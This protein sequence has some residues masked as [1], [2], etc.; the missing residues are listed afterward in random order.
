M[1][2][3]VLGTGLLGREIAIR[4]A[5]QGLRV[6]VW[7]RSADKAAPL[8][9]V[10]IGLADSAAAAIA[11]ADFTL[12]LLSDAAAIRETLFSAA[13]ESALA[14][15]IIV[16][17]GTI[18]PEESRAIA[19]TVARAGGDYLEAP[20]LGSLP[21]AR[22][23]RLIIMAGGDESLYQRC[24]P[25]FEALSQSPQRVGEIG[26]GAALKLAMNQLIAGLTASF[27]YSLG[28]VRSE[29]LDVEQFMALLRQSAL[30]APTFDK[31][32]GNYLSGDYSGANFPLKHLLKDL[33]L[34]R[35][36][37]EDKQLDTAPLAAL[38]AAFLRATAAGLADADYSAIYKA[39]VE[40]R[41]P[42]SKG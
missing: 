8:A 6:T 39:L 14:G 22:E 24:L 29:G 36:V 17:M 33:S 9:A 32:L 38:E 5:S 21:E 10:G 4:L 42:T 7:N 3:A 27:A 18:A 20:V 15:R 11:G 1:K 26:Q 35:R 40:A 12:L 30:Y 25:L 41:G 13:T 34:F 19:A 28:L 31:K 2:T 23:G 16:Q 37:A